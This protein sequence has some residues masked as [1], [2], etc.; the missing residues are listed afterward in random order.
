MNTRILTFISALLV[1]MSFQSFF[2]CMVFAQPTLELFNT[3]NQHYEKGQY[4]QAITQYERIIKS[5][6]NNA[7]IYYNLANAWFKKGNVAKAILYYE[8]A[9]IL[10][11]RDRD[12]RQNLKYALDQT[13]DKIE[14]PNASLFVT[15]GSSILNYLS[16]N[17]WTLVLSVLFCFICLGFILRMV[18]TRR[19]LR[20]LTLYAL[21]CMLFLFIVTG[22]FFAVKLDAVLY[23]TRGVI[24]V[25]EIEVRSGPS[26][27]YTTLLRIH[28]GTRTEVLQSRQEWLQIKL[29][30][31][32]QGWIPGSA[33]E[34]I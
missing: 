19:L 4:D 15:V 18:L 31:G 17:E 30:N 23:T 25:S 6:I 13:I 27:S 3:A 8:K 5:D 11:P 7:S 1:T 20:D 33:L 22:S 26:T 28:S 16:L 21:V 32:Y 34:P 2:L 9:R 14:N 10:E 29:E 24:M 12:I